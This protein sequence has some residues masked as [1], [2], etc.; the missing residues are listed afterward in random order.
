MVRYEMGAN[1]LEQ[2]PNYCEVVRLL[3]I[4]LISL[5]VVQSHAMLSAM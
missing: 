4:F 3:K 1:L 2:P 5:F